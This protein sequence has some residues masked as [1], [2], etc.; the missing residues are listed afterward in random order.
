MTAV[1]VQSNKSVSNEVT[2]S[3]M[4]LAT[5]Y[6]KNVTAFL[7]NPIVLLFFFFFFKVEA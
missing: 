1:T 4:L 3:Y 5:L 7:A 6:G 2:D